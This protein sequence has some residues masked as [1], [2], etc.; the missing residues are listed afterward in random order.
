MDSNSVSILDDSSSTPSSFGAT[1]ILRFC[2]IDSG[3]SS[4]SIGSDFGCPSSGSSSLCFSSSISQ[5]FD[6]CPK[7]AL[8]LLPDARS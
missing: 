5:T 4:E 2:S 8:E 1:S 6:P 3:S 7:S